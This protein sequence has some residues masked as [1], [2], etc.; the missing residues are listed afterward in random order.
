[1]SNKKISELPAS[2]VP[3][4]SALMAVVFGGITQGVALADF[5]KT[6]VAINVKA[7]G[8]K[9]DNST[10]DQTALNN[11]V[12]AALALGRAL[13]WPDG[14][15]V[16]N[17]NIPN[18]HLVRHTGPGA[19]K[20]GSD[21]FYVCPSS[22]QSNTLYV[23]TAGSSSNDGVTS[24]QPFTPSEIAAVLSNYGPM[25]NG[26]WSVNLAAG[27]YNRTTQVTI[28][29]LR[30][31]LPIT[32]AGPAASYGVPT[33]ILDG[34]SST[35]GVCGF[36]FRNGVR[37]VVR[38]LKVQNFA[39]TDAM[40]ITADRHCELFCD[41][42]HDTGCDLAGINAES[43]T[44]LYVTGGIHALN[45][46]YN[47]RAYGQCLVTIG[48]QSSGHRVT[49]GDATHAGGAGIL[50]RDNSSGHVDYCDIN[51]VHDG[52]GV[53]LINQSRVHLVSCVFGGTSANYYNI[54]TAPNC[55]Y[56]D[57]GTNTFNA[58]TSKS[59]VQWGFGIDSA[60]QQL[61]YYD[62]ATGWFKWGRKDSLTPK[63][64]FDIQDTAATVWGGSYNSNVLF[65][66][67]SPNN[68]YIGLGAGNAG[69]CGIMF[70]DVAGNRQGQIGYLHSSDVIFMRVN[71]VDSFRWHSTYFRPEVDNA[72]T[73]GGGAAANRWTTVYATTG[74]INTSDE[75]E[76]EQIEAIPDA[77]L[78][79]WQEVEWVR[80]K[81]RDAVQKKTDG[82]RWHY[83][84]I[85]QRVKS[86]FEAHGLDAFEH[87]LL[88]FDSWDAQP[89]IWRDD[90]EVRDRE[91]NVVRGAERV[92]VQAAREAGDRYGLRYDE[93][94]VLEAALM[95]RELSRL[96]SA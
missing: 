72:V 50:I 62:F 66:V 55:T 24:S 8:A 65:G 94:L 84:A 64:L 57:D 41:N 38:D 34:A 39:S 78:D 20:R 46:N 85:A 27:T 54:R 77:L 31:L 86:V 7:F 15:Y 30:S 40:G 33:A 92:R 96:R 37:A 71:A 80:Y 2:S 25:L 35:G 93:C 5:L 89:E 60:S 69:E 52:G 63:A 82:A 6:L 81:W 14:T 75:R 83:G 1:M 67:T 90:P 16:S 76:K 53:E 70:A 29:G 59:I 49:I 68:S 43:H 79:A 17:A 26:A 4:Y 23:G 48:Y 45:V 51:G 95:R 74:A 56:I 18:L 19:I 88:C 13:H 3:I 12:A 11:A 58:A 61:A 87:G 10:V 73:L 21:T 9:G 22:T 91:G 44:R 47:I 36:Y 28:D 32:F 42:V